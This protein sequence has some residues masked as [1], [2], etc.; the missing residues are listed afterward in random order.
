MIPVL[1]GAGRAEAEAAVDAWVAEQIRAG[2]PTNTALLDALPELGRRG[3][4][5]AENVLES[6]DDAAR[7]RALLALA[8]ADP[9]GAL[10][11]LEA[12][13]HDGP[14]AR[15]VAAVELGRLGQT[16]ADPA[17][18]ELQAQLAGTGDAV[19][20]AYARRLSRRD[21]SPAAPGEGL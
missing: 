11:T 2:G 16:A 1:C 12:A 15:L 10:P 8:W 6:K 7:A 5:A 20:V 18:A 9:K 13:L 14:L 3:A 17:L 4:R 19:L 21:L